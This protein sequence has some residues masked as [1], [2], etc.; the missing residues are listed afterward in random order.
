MS[1]CDLPPSLLRAS[2]LKCESEHAGKKHAQPVGVSCFIAT[3]NLH[4]TAAG[5]L[6]LALSLARGDCRWYRAAGA[7]QQQGAGKFFL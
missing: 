1:Y 6:L 4:A 3:G 2:L 5:L 7:L